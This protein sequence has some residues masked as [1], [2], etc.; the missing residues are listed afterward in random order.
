[1]LNCVTRSLNQIEI[2]KISLK[3]SM[4]VQYGYETEYQ[5]KYANNG[6]PFARHYQYILFCGR[7]LTLLN[8]G[9]YCLKDQVFIIESQGTVNLQ[10]RQVGTSVWKNDHFSTP[11]MKLDDKRVFYLLTSDIEDVKDIFNQIQ[12][13]RK[14]NRKNDDWNPAPAR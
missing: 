14:W 13:P 3:V 1:M 11:I 10:D 6:D 2:E 9:I 5:N 12:L 4:V 7:Q 8:T